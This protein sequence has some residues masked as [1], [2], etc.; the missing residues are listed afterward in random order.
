MTRKEEEQTTKIRNKNKLTLDATGNKKCSENIMNNIFMPV[1]LKCSQNG[2][3][4]R[5]TN[6]P[7]LIREEIENQSS[8]IGIKVYK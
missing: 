6:L 3:I 8:P 1:I 4:P 2:W 7:K 5:K